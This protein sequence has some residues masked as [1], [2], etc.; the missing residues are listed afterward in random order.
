MSQWVSEWVSQIIEYRA[1]ASQLKNLSLCYLKYVPIFFLSEI[2]LLFIYLKYVSYSFILNMCPLQIWNMSP[3]QF[4]K[5]YLLMYYPK[6]VYNYLIWNISLFFY[7]KCMFA[8]LLSEVSNIYKI[9]FLFYDLKHMSV[10]LTVC[11][12]ICVHYA[13]QSLK[14]SF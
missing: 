1:A 14:S 11:L 4:S 6:Y 10:V 2:C 13:F 5:I 7:L 3:F 8:I 12:F 9:C